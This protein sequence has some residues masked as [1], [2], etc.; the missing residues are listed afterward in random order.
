MVENNQNLNNGSPWWKPAVELFSQ[1]STWIVA[2]II[3]ALVVGKGLDKHFGTRPII[4]LILAGVG[5]L[6]TL[7]G[8]M[9]VIKKYTKELKKIEEENLNNKS[10]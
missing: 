10:Q 6:V 3:L 8:I 1:V 4:F 2:P 9:R 5:F 7:V